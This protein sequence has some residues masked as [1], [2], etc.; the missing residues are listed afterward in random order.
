MEMTNSVCIGVYK[1]VIASLLMSLQ[2]FPPI[3]TCKFIHLRRIA[4]IWV[5][6][7][8]QIYNL[9]NEY[10]ILCIQFQQL[11]NL[12][13]SLIIL[14]KTIAAHDPQVSLANRS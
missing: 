3:E 7:L 5:K 12:H 14:K 10:I 13:P 6:E 9:S 4:D 11:Y 1:I 2:A 8:Q